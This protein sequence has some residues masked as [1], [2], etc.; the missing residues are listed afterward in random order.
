MREHDLVNC[1]SELGLWPLK[2]SGNFNY[3]LPCLYQHTKHAKGYDTHPSATVS[4]NQGISWF[5]CYACSTRR[6]LIDAIVDLAM[7]STSTV[8]WMR[9]SSKYD[10]VESREQGAVV[11]RP[12]GKLAEVSTDRNCSDGLARLLKHGYPTHVKAFLN[13]KGVYEATARKFG[14]AF[15]P[16]GHVDEFMHKGPSGEPEPVKVDTLLIPTLIRTKE[17]K[18]I[19]VGAQG[20][21]LAGNG[22]KYYTIYPHQIGQFL[23]GQ[24]LA[25]H[26]T[27][28]RIFLV[29]G[30]FDV[31]HLWQEKSF[32]LGLFGLHANQQRCLR[33]RNIR[34]THIHVFLDPDTAGQGAVKK[35]IQCL[36]DAGLEA[37]PIVSSKQPK[38]CTAEELV[39]F[40]SA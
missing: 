4:F 29:E 12:G 9:I 14:V 3:S 16:A 33:L 15:V 36:T 34:P 30:C 11:A 35:V 39:T 20:R 25:K 23:Y 38:E 6:P 5:R 7:T 19:C 37:S 27:G 13:S 18:V 28:K 17:N 8:G 31:M 40:L 21:P 22:A 24:H 32:A 26:L 10:E 1:L 2:K